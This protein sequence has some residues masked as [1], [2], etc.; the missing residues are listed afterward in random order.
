MGTRQDCL[1]G[2]H[3]SDNQGL[4]WWCGTMVNQDWNDEYYGVS[5]SEQN[6]ESSDMQAE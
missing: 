1:D 2:Q 6:A 5:K 4:C 3:T